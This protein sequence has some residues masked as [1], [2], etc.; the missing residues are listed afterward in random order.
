MELRVHL[1]SLH[2]R[3]GL[4]LKGTDLVCDHLELA[5][6]DGPEEPVSLLDIP[7]DVDEFERRREAGDRVRGAPVGNGERTSLAA[8]LEVLVL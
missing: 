1:G 8:R 2:E 5:A 3:V 6:D 7:R 4:L